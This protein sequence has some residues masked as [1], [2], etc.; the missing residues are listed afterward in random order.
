MNRLRS[1]VVL[2]AAAAL[3]SLTALPASSAAT[4]APFRA[5]IGGEAS[6]TLGCCYTF[7]GLE[8]TQ[9]VLPRIG[10]ATVSGYIEWCGISESSPCPER[11]GTTLSLV[12]TAASGDTLTLG[13]Y[14]TIGDPSLTWRVVGR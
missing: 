4:R 13:R 14:N 6:F 5:T 11:N 9:T 2:V 1:G 12:L 8:P 7:I 10:K 3:V